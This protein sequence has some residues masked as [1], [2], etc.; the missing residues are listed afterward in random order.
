MLREQVGEKIL[1]ESEDVGGDETPDLLCTDASDAD[2]TI[3][4]AH[5]PKDDPE[6]VQWAGTQRQTLHFPAV[7]GPQSSSRHLPRACSLA[8]EGETPLPPLPWSCTPPLTPTCWTPRSDSQGEV[9][10]LSICRGE[11]SGLSVCGRKGVCYADSSLL[12]MGT[13]NGASGGTCGLGGPLAKLP[14]PR[15]ASERTRHL[16]V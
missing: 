9:S 10:A 2:D 1:Q 4:L 11:V 6:P 12:N 15:P 16:A 5:W 8:R 13:R 3:G 7:G 14:S